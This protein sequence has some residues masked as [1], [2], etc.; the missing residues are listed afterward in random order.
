MEKARSSD[1]ALLLEHTDRHCGFAVVCCCGGIAWLR[2]TV[3]AL[4]GRRT[5]D[6]RVT[7]VVLPRGALT[8]G[9]AFDEPPLPLF[10]FVLLFATVLLRT[11]GGRRVTR[12]PR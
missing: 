10:A 11:M 5:A 7:P 2:C 1:R 3:M 8:R 9:A 4:G 6:A 12:M